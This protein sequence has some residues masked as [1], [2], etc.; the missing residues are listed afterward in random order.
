MDGQMVRA[1]ARRNLDKRIGAPADRAC[2]ERLVAL[3]AHGGLLPVCSW[4]R[5][6]RD[7]SGRWIQA[8]CGNP[9]AA[10]VSVTHGVCPDCAR[11][12][13]GR[14]GEAA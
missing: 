2:A 11:K 3:R 13:R 10:G 6:F 9:E 14:P 7:D 8:D 12:L 1:A 5:R 4:C